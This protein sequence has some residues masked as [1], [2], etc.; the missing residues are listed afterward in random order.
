MAARPAGEQVV[1]ACSHEVSH[2]LLL[3]RY[4]TLSEALGEKV[5][6]RILTYHYEMKN[7]PPE[8]AADVVLAWEASFGVKDHLEIIYNEAVRPICSPTYAQT[9]AKIL[10]GPVRGW[11]GLTFLDHARPN[12]GWATWEGWFRAAG[13]PEQRPAT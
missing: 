1:I 9:H 11:G 4:D 10:N 2:F 12:E 13:R 5:R 8:P 7:L 3:P 6:V